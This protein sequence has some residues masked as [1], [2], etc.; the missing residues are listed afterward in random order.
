MDVHT[1]IHKHTYTHQHLHTH[2][3]LYIYIYAFINIYAKNTYNTHTYFFTHIQIKGF[4]MG[5]TDVSLNS[6]AMLCEKFSGQST[7]GFF[8]AAYAFG[9]LAGMYVN[10]CEIILKQVY[11]NLFTIFF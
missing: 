9:A 8:H 7:I 11:N 4:G 1:C 5:L 2:I 3:H 6:Q 10:N